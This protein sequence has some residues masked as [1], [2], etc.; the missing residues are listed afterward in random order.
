MDEMPFIIQLC[1]QNKFTFQSKFLVNNLCKKV[2]H[3]IPFSHKN[4][5]PFSF[6]GTLSW[7]P[8]ESVI[9]EL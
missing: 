7:V 4:L 1:I 8:L 3:E 9:L 6:S 2:L 5:Y